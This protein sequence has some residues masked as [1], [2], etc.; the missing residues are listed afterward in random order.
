MT[1]LVHTNLL[2]LFM[3][4]IFLSLV[5]SF[6]LL[7]SLFISC[8]LFLH[9]VI[10]F[11]PILYLVIFFYL[12]ISFYVY[13]FLSLFIFLSFYPFLPIIASSQRVLTSSCCCKPVITS[14]SLFFFLVFLVPLWEFLALHTSLS[15]IF[16]VFSRFVILILNCFSPLSDVLTFFSVGYFYLFWSI[17]EDTTWLLTHFYLFYCFRLCQFSSF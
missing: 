8:Y 2:S 12:F 5:I 7:W 11:Y 17:L 1:Y 14:F 3:S 9:L 10:S 16:T 13:M 4:F 6:Y 15:A